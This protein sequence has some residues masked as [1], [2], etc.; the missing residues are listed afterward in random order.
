MHC[1][2]LDTRLGNATDQRR[3]TLPH[4]I[5]GSIT[6]MTFGPRYTA[7]ATSSGTIEATMTREW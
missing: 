5:K 3:F 2:E 6:R 4:R 1:I 7:M